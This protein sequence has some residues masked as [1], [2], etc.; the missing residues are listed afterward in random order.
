M[1]WHCGCP[2]II[3]IKQWKGIAGISPLLPLKTGRHTSI[4]LLR[5]GFGPLYHF[6][7][8]SQWNGGRSTIFN[9][10]DKDMLAIAFHFF[11]DMMEGCPPVHCISK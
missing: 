8:G 3:C 1:E 4:C 10:N 9:G 5:I 6:K 11:L 7:L 2:S